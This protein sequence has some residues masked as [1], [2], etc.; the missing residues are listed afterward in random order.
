MK[1]NADVIAGLQLVLKDQL[2]AI[3]QYFLHARMLKNWGFQ[4]LGKWEYRASIEVM[5]QG[6]SVLIAIAELP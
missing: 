6:R 3:N 1:G 4:V 2:T 5:K